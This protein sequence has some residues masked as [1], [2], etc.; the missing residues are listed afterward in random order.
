[1]LE[2]CLN[3]CLI[4]MIYKI[5]VLRNMCVCLGACVRAFGLSCKC[6]L[7]ELRLL[8]RACLSCV[9]LNPHPV[10]MHVMSHNPSRAAPFLSATYRRV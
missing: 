7:A 9:L 8:E 5:I 10:A 4:Y 1:M 2:L 6:F 3:V